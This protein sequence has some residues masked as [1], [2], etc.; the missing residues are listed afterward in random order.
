MVF[1]VV[2]RL[3]SFSFPKSQDQARPISVGCLA[4]ASGQIGA[5]AAGWPLQALAQRAGWS[6]IG[7]TNA[8]AGL[9][10]AMAFLPLWSLTARDNKEK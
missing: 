3:L 8:M 2:C 4:K 5:A 7:Y 1:D 6:C 9:L 10:A